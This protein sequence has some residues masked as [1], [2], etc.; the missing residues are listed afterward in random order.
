VPQDRKSL[1]SSAAENYIIISCL[2]V[3]AFKLKKGRDRQGMQQAWE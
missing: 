3:K 2:D 1:R